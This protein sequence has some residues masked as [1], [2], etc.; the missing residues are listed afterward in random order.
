MNNIKIQ[1]EYIRLDALLKL[2]GL[3]DTGGMAKQMIQSGDV[4]VNGDVCLLRGKKIRQGDTV[5][6]TAQPDTV[7]TVTEHAD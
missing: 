7:W 2:T 1:T 5:C 3:A 4:L 6:L